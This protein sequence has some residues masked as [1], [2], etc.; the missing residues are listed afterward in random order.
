[1]E[2][3]LI[4]INLIML[5]VL[6]CFRKYIST[7]IQRSINHKYDEKIEAFRAELK[8]TEEEFKFF[9]DFVQKSLSEN[10]HIFK[11]YLNSAINNLW[12]I[13]VDLKAK[14]YN[15]AKTLSH[16]NIQYL[17]TQIA[18][19]DEKS[20]RLSKIYCSKINV[21]EFNKTTL[22]AEK[23]RI[24]LPQ[25]IWALYFAYETI[26]SY[27]ITQFLVVDMG[28]DPDKFTAKDKIDSF[29]KNVIPGY[30]NIE[31]SRLPNYLDFLEE[32]LIIEIQRLSLPSTIE[33]N[34]ERVKEIIQSISVAKNA[35]DKERED[36]S[37]K[38]D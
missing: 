30:I 35:I 3:I 10:E 4:I 11:P 31:N 9:H 18:N 27:V 38:D 15:L 34:I 33:A 24:W 21:D 7:Y 25:M 1:M 5:G 17:K 13:F 20:K 14:H 2:G 29:I 16:L 12:D 8:K 37:K 6:F 28:E 32:Q 22:I 36:L 26:I 23:N 19:N